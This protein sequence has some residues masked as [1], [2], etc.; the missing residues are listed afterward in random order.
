MT[1]TQYTDDEVRQLFSRATEDIPPHLDL[2]AGFQARRSRQSRL[3]RPGTRVLLA[4]GTATATAAAAVAVTLTVGP[5]PSAR[6][7][8]TQAAAATAAQS[9]RIT[10]RVGTARQSPPQ[11]SQPGPVTITGA[12]DPVRK[13]GEETTG[14]GYVVRFINGYLYVP[15]PAK[16]WPQY[17]KLHPGAPAVGQI[18]TRLNV[19]L[20]P[21]SGPPDLAFILLGVTEPGV[22][23]LNPQTLLA[24]LKSASQVGRV[25]PASGPGWS[26]T[27][28]SFSVSTVRSVAPGDTIDV[29][30]R[31]TVDVDQQGRVRR[32]A[33]TETLQ[34]S[35]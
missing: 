11:L 28:Y 9:Y 33:A 21:D 17:R 6:A 34:D 12:F 23:Q 30:L 1:G 8:V 26:G 20:Q 27:R 7:A 22:L 18:W 3:H 15:L 19:P 31:G 13:T 4:A 16:F 35:G 14:D 5:A 32:L 25:G 29:S 2:L 24:L 10:S